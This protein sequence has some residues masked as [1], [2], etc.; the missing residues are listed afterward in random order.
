MIN[1]RDVE[2]SA[3][4]P[5]TLRGVWVDLLTGDQLVLQDAF[6]AAPYSY[7]IMIRN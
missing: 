1:P 5:E 4:C 6:S 7:R 3:V 2:I